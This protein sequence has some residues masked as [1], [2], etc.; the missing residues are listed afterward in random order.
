MWTLLRLLYLLLNSLKVQQLQSLHVPGL[1]DGIA[2]SEKTSHNARKY[3]VLK[4]KV[5]QR[6]RLSGIRKVFMMALLQAPRDSS[7]TSLWSVVEARFGQVA[8][9]PD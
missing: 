8:Q 5:L 4:T 7:C 9:P 6:Q 2:T 3:K 1:E